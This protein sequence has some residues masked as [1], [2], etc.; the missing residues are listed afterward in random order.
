MQ[1]IKK[2]GK[3]CIE[4]AKYSLQALL[5]SD[6]IRFKRVLFGLMVFCFLGSL[7]IFR[8]SGFLFFRSSGFG[9]LD[10]LVS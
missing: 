2:E 7:V 8:L 10:Q 4:G 5:E 6:I 9:L 3:S 1:L